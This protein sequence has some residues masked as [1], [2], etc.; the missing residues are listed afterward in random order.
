[1][2]TILYTMIISLFFSLS[3]AAKE[4]ITT[5][6]AAN[7]QKTILVMGDS[8]SAGYGLENEQGW[9]S[10]LQKNLQ[11]QYPG[12]TIKNASISGE[13]T[14][15]GASRIIQEALTTKPA[16]VVIELGANDGLRG[17]PIDEMRRN[18]AR[19]IGVAQHVGADVVLVG[20]QIPPN[21]G[22]DYT[23]QFTATY[24]LLAKQFKTDYIPFLLESV[25]MQ[26][27]SFQ[28]DNL[29]PVAEVQPAIRDHVLKTLKPM[30]DARK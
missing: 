8:L 18:L 13:T 19:M 2:K 15:G 14:A 21:Y 26:R 16:I 7:T 1:M 30:L 23:R 20:M 6:Q 4:P 22:S 28:D 17:L 11:T 3:V 24:Q 27:T 10:L 12:W 25:P 5:Q 9:V 29:H